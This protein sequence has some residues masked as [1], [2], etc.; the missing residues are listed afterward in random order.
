MRPLD[1]AAPLEK[2]LSI[3]LIV[4][5]AMLTVAAIYVHSPIALFLSIPAF[6]YP[7]IFLGD[8]YFWMRNFGMNLDPHAPLSSSVKPFVPPILGE[9]MVGQFR[10]IASWEIGLWLSILASILIIVGLYYHRK[11]YKPLLEADYRGEAAG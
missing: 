7:V 9:G 6:F 3:I 5:L 8:L 4:V 10:T 1:Q 2:S 11:A